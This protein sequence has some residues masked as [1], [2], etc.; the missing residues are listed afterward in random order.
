MQNKNKKFPN[1]RCQTCGLVFSTKPIRL[2]YKAK[3]WRKCH[4]RCNLKPLY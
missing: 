2:R 4:N 3:D 1:V